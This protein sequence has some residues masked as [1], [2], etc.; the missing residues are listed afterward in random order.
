M[1]LLFVIIASG[2]N[3]HYRLLL[4]SLL[5][6]LLPFSETFAQKKKPTAPAALMPE[7]VRIVSWEILEN[8]DTI[9][10]IDQHNHRHGRW[11]VFHEGRYGE[12]PYYE[13][14]SFDDDVKSGTWTV[15]DKN[16]VTLSTEF[17]RQG[18]LD[19]EARYYEEGRLYCIGHYLALR[20]K[21]AYDTIMVEN[22]ETNVLR[23]VVV[24]AQ[25]GSVRHGLWTFY[26]AQSGAIDRVVEYQADEVIYDRDYTQA[27][28][29]D[30]VELA[31]RV[32]SLPHVSHQP[33]PSVWFLEKGKKPAQYTDFPEN[34]QYVKPNVRSGK[35]G[36]GR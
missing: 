35:K 23:P 8:G 9:N 2:M 6:G 17:F 5:L 13:Y 32:K 30:S 14:G 33:P 21:T 10:R 31:Q 1:C 7:S 19:G 22:P 25:T 27:T 29:A 24:K 28:K 12:P 36:S 20:S 18:V 16:G 15:Y 4:S 34:T 26:N 11:L 3:I